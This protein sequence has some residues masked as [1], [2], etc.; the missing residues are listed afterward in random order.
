MKPFLPHIPFERG[1]Y[2]IRKAPFR[3]RRGLIDLFLPL[4]FKPYQLVGISTFSDKSEGCRA[5]SGLVPPPL[6]IRV[7]HHAI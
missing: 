6:L 2:K 1:V 7:I 4:S 5:S 3:I